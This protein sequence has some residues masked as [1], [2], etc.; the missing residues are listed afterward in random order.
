MYEDLGLLTVDPT[1]GADVADLFNH[2]SGYTK[3]RDYRTLLVAPDTLRPGL[4]QLI[5]DEAAHAQAGRPAGVTLKLNSLVDELVIDALYDAST[6]GVPVEIVVRGM[7]ALRPGVPGLSETIKV[8]SI[9]GRFLEHSRVFHFTAGGDQ[10]T[11]IGSAD[12]MHRNLDRRVEALVEIRDP[13]V[14]DELGDL[15]AFATDPT[16]AGWTLDVEGRW[17]RSVTGPDGS[18]LRDYQ[19]TLLDAAAL[20]ADKVRPEPHS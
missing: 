3:H 15:L 5:A 17:S 16:T 8:R 13:Q 7:C 12:I 11:F 20:R 2:L 9:L 1:I 14:K 19:Q 18:P 10:R 6:A 4:L